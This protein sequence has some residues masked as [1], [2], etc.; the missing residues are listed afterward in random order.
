MK[1]YSVFLI[2]VF[3]LFCWLQG[4][5]ADR[6]HHWVDPNGVTHLSK[7]PPPEDGELMEIMEYSSRTD[8]PARP[9]PDGF[10]AE[11]KKQKENVV[12]ITPPVAADQDKNDIDLTSA[13][14]IFANGEEVHVYVTEREPM[15]GPQD[16]E[17]YKGYIPKNQKQL[18]KS[19]IGNIIY[20]YRRSVDDRSYG[21]NRADCADGNVISIP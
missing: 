5:L 1:K 11:L 14:Y 18:I 8:E 15:I 16:K 2:S 10:P 4:G 17:L 9:D 7:E 19:S 6:L 3:T 21:D 13:C 20:T 12:E